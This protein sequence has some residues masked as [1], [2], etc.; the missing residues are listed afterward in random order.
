MP[1]RLATFKLGV[2]D[3]VKTATNST[4][5]MGVG[6]SGLGGMR[7]QDMPSMILEMMLS[8][9]SISSSFRFYY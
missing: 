1:F 5:N 7:F 6:T 3:Y 9:I 2:S 8:M 4:K